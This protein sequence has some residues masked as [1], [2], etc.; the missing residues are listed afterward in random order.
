MGFRCVP[1]TPRYSATFRW[2]LSEKSGFESTLK[3]SHFKE[4]PNPRGAGFSDPRPDPGSRVRTRDPRPGP[5]I[6]DENLVRTRDPRPGPRIQ[7][8][9]LGPDPGSKTRTPDPKP[10]P[11]ILGPDPGSGKNW[12]PLGL[13][14]NLY[15]SKGIIEAECITLKCTYKSKDIN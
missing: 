2:I 8:L 11:G 4:G 12:P 3:T 15:L 6:Q 9:K 10:G 14:P 13:A 1:R 5:R 7:S